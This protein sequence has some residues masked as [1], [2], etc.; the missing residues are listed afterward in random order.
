[1]AKLKSTSPRRGTQCP[2]SPQPGDPH[3][4]P[5]FWRVVAPA[6][7]SY[8]HDMIGCQTEDET[9]ARRYFKSFRTTG[10]PVR[11]EFVRSGPL[12]KGYMET[13]RLLRASNA[14]NPGTEMQPVLRAWTNQVAS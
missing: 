5:A 10:L 2:L 6:C 1:M 12:P 3:T 8:D 9:E 14:Q 4:W 7:G 11:L 13:L